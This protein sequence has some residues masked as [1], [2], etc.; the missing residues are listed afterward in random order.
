[1]FRNW[2]ATGALGAGG[3]CVASRNRST[4][5]TFETGKQPENTHYLLQQRHWLFLGNSTRCRQLHVAW[6]SDSY[7]AGHGGFG[8]D[9]AGP[10]PTVRAGEKKQS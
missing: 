7:E 2:A 5:P 9:P 6:R 8:R 4:H 10:L 1:M 3:G